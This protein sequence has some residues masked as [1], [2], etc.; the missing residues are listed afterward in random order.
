M[1]KCIFLAAGSG[2][3]LRPYTNDIP[4]CLIPFRGRPLLSHL[5]NLARSCGLHD[6]IIV[7]GFLGDRL[8]FPNVKYV[9]NPDGYNMLHSLFCADHELKGEVVV[10]YTDILYESAVMKKLLV[11]TSDISV[12]VDLAWE[13][14]YRARTHDPLSIAESLVISNAKI[15]KIGM[16]PMSSRD[17]QGQYI[18]LMKFSANGVEQLKKCYWKS[19]RMFWGQPWQQAPKFE[20]AYMTD[21]LQA[22]IESGVEVNTVPIERGWL[23]FD[24]VS[25]YEKTLHWDK[26]GSLSR[27]IKI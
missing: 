20:L 1:T 19:R 14:Y 3:R 24:T 10:S 22:L 4:K 16:R 12:V 18:G 25:D 11:S 15:L 21:I 9:D 8:N 27:F 7:R 13:E 6:I 23:E 26:E 2:S 5:L 17:V